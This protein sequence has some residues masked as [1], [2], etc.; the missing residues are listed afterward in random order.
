M[1]R[2][3]PLVRKRCREMFGDEWWKTDKKKRQDDAITY[4]NKYLST[5]NTR[6]TQEDINALYK[7]VSSKIPRAKHIKIETLNPS[8]KCYEVMRE[9]MKSGTEHRWLF[10]GTTAA[11][12]P[13]ICRD[14]FNRSFCGRNATVYGNG[15]Y[16]T[17]DINYS[18]QNIYSVPDDKHIKRIFAASVLVG[19]TCQ[20]RS[21]QITPDVCN[22]IMCDSTVDNVKNPSIYVIY[23]DF[24][25]IPEYL[26]SFTMD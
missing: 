20:G 6:N 4:L 14:G 2:T 17:S 19:H 11:A 23:K 25:A 18:A 16:F 26:I 3:D 13:L 8:R 10:H 7:I 21:G 1:K 22:N 24:Q 5:S 12:V 9:L 15:V